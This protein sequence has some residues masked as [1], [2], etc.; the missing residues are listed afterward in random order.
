LSSQFNMDTAAGQVFLSPTCVRNEKE[1]V[2][3]FQVFR[4]IGCIQDKVYDKPGSEDG[5]RVH[6]WGFHDI[7][8]L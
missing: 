8:I 4:I 7:E 3:E 2:G 6:R 1:K 5:E